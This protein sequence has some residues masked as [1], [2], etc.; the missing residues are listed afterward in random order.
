MKP[1]KEQ[2]EK[3][4]WKA[5]LNQIFQDAFNDT[6]R[7]RNKGEKKHAIDYLKSMHQDYYMVCE[8]AGLD[9][10]YVYTKVKK[11]INLD[12]LKKLGVIWN[13]DKENNN[14]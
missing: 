1:V 14:D 5:V 9:A 12:N 10:N 8:Y 13:Y 4:L 6:Y 3:R 11:K 2:P 7:S